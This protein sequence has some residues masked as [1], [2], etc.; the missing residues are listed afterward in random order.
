M[1]PSVLQRIRHLPLASTQHCILP[2]MLSMPPCAGLAAEDRQRPP[3]GGGVPTGGSGSVKPHPLPR[4]STCRGAD[5]HC[6]FNDKEAEV[7]RDSIN[8]LRFHRN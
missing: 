7:Q 1:E 3:H 8:W 2:A 6:P 4:R 5:F